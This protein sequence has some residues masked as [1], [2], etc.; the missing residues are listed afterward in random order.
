MCVSPVRI[1]NPNYGCTADLLRKTTDCVS[2]YINVPCGVCCEC[3]ARRQSDLVQRVRVLSLDHYLFFYT[4]TYNSESLPVYECST[5]FRVAYADHSDVTNMFKR[6]RKGNLFGFPFLYLSVSERGSKRSR[7]HFHGLIFIRKEY[8]KNDPL[9]TAQMEFKIRNVLFKEWRRN[10][11]STRN[12]KWKPLFTYRSKYVSGTRYSNFDCH[13]VTPHSSASGESDVAFYVSKYVLKTSANE[14][15]LQ[16]ALRLNLPPAEYAVVWPV[17][18]SKC[19]KS[20]SFGNASESEINFVKSQI[21]LSREDPTGLHFKNS[22]GSLAP[23]PR[24]YRRYVSAEDAV[25]SVTARGGP[26]AIR[27]RMQSDIDLSLQKGTIRSQK[28][29]LRDNSLIS[30]DD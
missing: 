28:V 19:T 23:L 26:L 20:L 11:G 15:R 24:F 17:V 30:N 9:F 16:Q 5:G 6:I 14:V 12:P 18:R 13:Y 10:Y 21:R 25:S 29:A 4:L 1:P 7:P 22:D 8:G 2:R 27:E 3:I